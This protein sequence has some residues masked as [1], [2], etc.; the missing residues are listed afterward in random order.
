LQFRELPLDVVPFC[1]GIFKNVVGDI[2]D[3]LQLFVLLWV[4]T[5]VT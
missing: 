5:I 1:L 2:V 4:L 3:V